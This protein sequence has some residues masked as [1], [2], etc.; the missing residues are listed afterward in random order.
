MKNVFAWSTFVQ[1]HPVAHRHHPQR[2][3]KYIPHEVELDMSGYTVSC[4]YKTFR[5]V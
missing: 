5:R 1:L 2:V 4:T 3:R